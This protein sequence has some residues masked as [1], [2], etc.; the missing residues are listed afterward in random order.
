MKA[1]DDLDAHNALLIRIKTLSA[2][3]KRVWVSTGCLTPRS[4][5]LPATNTMTGPDFLEEEDHI[6]A[7]GLWSCGIA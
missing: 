5:S 2:P 6:E 4:L 3:E 7:T 1:L